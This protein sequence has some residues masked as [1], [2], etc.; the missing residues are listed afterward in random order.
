[1]AIAGC[2]SVQSIARFLWLA[3]NLRSR[4]SAAGITDYKNMGGIKII[5]ISYTMN[6]NYVY[7]ITLGIIETT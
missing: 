3:R 2:V 1:M 5:Y 7:V 6:L 4:L